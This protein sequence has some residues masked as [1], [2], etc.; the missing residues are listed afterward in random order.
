LPRSE[1]HEES[2]IVSNF[3]SHLRFALRQIFRQPVYSS[4]IVGMLA[5]GIAGNSAIFSLV[6]RLLIEP[7]MFTDA[8]RLVVL[9]EQAPLWNLDRTSI[10][11][12]DFHFWRE[13]NHSFDSMA[14]L[15]DQSF[16]LVRGSQTERVEG[17]EVTHDLT[18]V[19]GVEPQLGRMFTA[20]EDRRD[21]PKVAVLGNGLWQRLFAGSPDAL[22][23]TLQLDGES[24]EV[25]GVLPAGVAYPPTAEL[26]TPV[27][28]DA[29]KDYDSYRYSGVGR[30]LPG[31]TV[32]Q[33][34]ADL[35]VIHKTLGEKWKFKE[36]VSSVVVP[37][38][39]EL[40]KD[41]RPVAWGLQIAV[42]LVLLIACANVAS[43]M[44]ARGSGRGREMAVRLALGGDRASL[45][46]QLLVESLVLAMA[47]GVLGVVL[48]YFGL[49]ELGSLAAKQLPFWVGF[50]PD[51]QA[52][53]VCLA[54][55][56]ATVLAFGLIPAWKT[57]QVDLQASL[58][59][60]EARVGGGVSRR[61]LLTGL[62]GVEMAL[63][64]ALL[65][66]AGLVALSQQRLMHQDPGF[67]PANRLVF[68]VS[69]PPAD[70][71]ENAT[72]AAFFDRLRERLSVL[73][74]VESASFAD[75]PPLFGH[76]GFFMEVEGGAIRGS[77]QDGQ[78]EQPV[79]LLR[80]VGEAYVATL[81]ITMLQG[82]FITV[83][84]DSQAPQRELVVNESFARK[85]WGTID[86]VGK[87]ARFRGDDAP[88]MEVV[89]VS[90]DARQYGLAEPP[91]PAVYMG[92]GAQARN[93]MV[94]VLHTAVPPL[95]LADDALR[96][97]QELDPKLPIYR[98]NTYESELR[99]SVALRRL[100]AWLFGL[101]AVV[102]LA[103]AA[104]GT[105]GVLSY[106]VEERRRDLGVHLALGAT[107]WRIWRH[108]VGRGLLPV[109][110]GSALGLLSAM[111]SA[112]VLASLLYGVDPREPRVFALVAAVLFVA[113][114]VANTVPAWRAARL[115]P[116][117]VLRAD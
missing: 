2:P 30:L 35:D 86:V 7:L 117:Q 44:L 64:Q 9:D 19:L 61:R 71:A 37:L 100:A 108:V 40:V 80:H 81:G 60:S 96:V 69:L 89:G 65:V 83:A 63:A 14:V 11:F 72:S 88:W 103:L 47:G 75:H 54:V 90:R 78:V 4:L 84:A 99:S 67:D 17:A 48:G 101:F 23:Q 36:A 94:M 8:E 115:D 111:A 68:Q 52:L 109:C 29:E 34:R 91:K 82:R 21:G 24:Y 22:G 25:I 26:W 105:Y 104:A 74:G 55:S 41:S 45:T 18:R 42:A 49:R 27:A 57:T 112:K 85:F 56:I 77:E 43:L 12:T 76:S 62:V 6:H 106:A 33:A 13:N 53:G 58:A 32:D 93:T 97:V 15:R 59:A 113:A 50:G 95:S 66:G 51:P 73:P 28:G 38:R 1:F 102:A 110:L 114:M 46:G 16:N 20:E 39:D 116:M 98:L 107:P 10:C 31:L 87:R 70:Y 3:V 92:R 79:A 5:L